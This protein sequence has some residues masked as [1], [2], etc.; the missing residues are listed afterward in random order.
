MLTPSQVA[1]V[2][3]I[4]FNQKSQPQI[5]IATRKSGE[6]SLGKLRVAKE[7]LNGLYDSF[8]NV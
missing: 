4:L 2:L 7:D 8:M 6:N 3:S 5:N 1:E